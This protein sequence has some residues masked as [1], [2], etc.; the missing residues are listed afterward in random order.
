MIANGIMRRTY[1]TLYNRAALVSSSKKIT[2]FQMFGDES[3]GA[4][5]GFGPIA[6]VVGAVSRVDAEKRHSGCSSI[7]MRSSGRQRVDR[8]A[9]QLS[10]GHPPGAPMRGQRQG[11]ATS[12]RASSRPQRLNFAHRAD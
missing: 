7:A 8:G 9:C 11:P 5:T 12:S 3:H 6:L 2:S 10:R 1:W 4:I